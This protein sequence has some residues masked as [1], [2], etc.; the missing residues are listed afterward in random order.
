VIDGPHV[1]IHD[2]DALISSAKSSLMIDDPSI[3]WFN[4]T[5]SCIRNWAFDETRLGNC[6]AEKSGLLGVSNVDGKVIL[7]L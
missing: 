7:Q 1:E 5:K 3:W 2:P 4:P 6:A